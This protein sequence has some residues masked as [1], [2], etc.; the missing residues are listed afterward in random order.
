[1][2][3]SVRNRRLAWDP[4]KRHRS[5]ASAAFLPSELIVEIISWLPVKYL[6]QFRCV[7]KFY[8]TLISDPYF[9]Q[10]HLEK[11]ARN[12]HL[13]LM[14]Q[15]DLLRED[16]SIIFLSVS[17][18]LGNKYTTPP[19]QSGT[20]Y[21]SCIIGSCNGLLCLVDFHCPDYYYYYYLYFWNPATRTKFRNILITLSR[22]FKFSFGYDTLSKTYK[23]IAFIVESVYGTSVVKVLSMGDDS[24]RNIQCF[25]VLPLYWFH[26]DKSQGVYLSGTINWL[27]LRNYFYS[28]YEFDNV[29]KITV[30]QYVIVS[31]DLS[32]E[33]Y[34]QLLLPRGFDEVPRVQ[35]TIV[36]LMDSLCF[37]HDFKGS[38][39]V[40]WKMKDFRVQESWIQLLKISYQNFCSSQSLLKFET[41][42]FL[43]LYLSK[44]GDALILANDQI[45]T[46]FIY[47]CREN[48]G[49]PIQITNKVRWLWA[50]D[51]VESLV[52]TS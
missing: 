38:H 10:M 51:Y 13:A 15:D 35:P 8:K 45:D 48:R 30:E 5:M 49:E 34:T 40:I 39:F 2:F 37:G 41:M 16:G 32:T 28:D 25:P 18:L 3:P 52:S 29:S 36:V 22:D 24:W 21:H 23:V 6:M 11:S 31:L 50:K 47:K 19:F 26:R 12:P 20:F 27:A 17:R 43:P 42:E 14:W 44:K 4:L 46:A 33:S 7:S 9:V 1:M